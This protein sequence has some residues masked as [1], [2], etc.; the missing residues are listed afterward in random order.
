I[1]ASSSTKRRA[2]SR[3]MPPAPPV[4]TATFP[5]RRPGISSP[6]PWPGGCS[7][8][9]CSSRGTGDQRRTLLPGNV[10][11]SV[12]VGLEDEV[13]VATLPGGHGVA[14]DGVHLHVHRQQVVAALRVVLD[15]LIEEVGRCEAF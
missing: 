5:S 12:H 14:F 11:Q 8:P 13:A 10:P 7:L 3:P 6:P 4:M 15:H 2:V 9:P 1:L